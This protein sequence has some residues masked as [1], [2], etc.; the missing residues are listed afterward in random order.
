MLSYLKANPK[1]KIISYN[2]FKIRIKRPKKKHLFNSPAPVFEEAK[3]FEPYCAGVKLEQ[4]TN[5]AERLGVN[6][7]VIT[8]FNGKWYTLEGQELKSGLN[9]RED[10]GFVDLEETG[11][12]R[13]NGSYFHGFHYFEYE[14]I[15]EYIRRNIHPFFETKIVEI[16]VLES[17]A[18]GTYKSMETH[19]TTRFIF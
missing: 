4:F 6:Y 5:I 18:R 7:I 16:T 17:N 13:M 1:K 14:S 3:I 11:R 10:S 15:A 9:K 19:V 12:I 2:D 8:A